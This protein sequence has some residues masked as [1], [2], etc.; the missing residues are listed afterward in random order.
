[1]TQ[2]Q[3]DTSAPARGADIIPFPGPGRRSETAPVSTPAPHD[4]DGDDDG[5]SAA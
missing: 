3:D 1:M 4:A 2:R 5:P